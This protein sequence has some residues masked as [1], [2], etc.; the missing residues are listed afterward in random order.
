MTAN[1]KDVIK[2]YL[3][4]RTEAEFIKAEAKERVDVVEAKMQKLEA[5]LH[6]QMNTLGVTSLKSEFGTAFLSTTDYARVENWD[7]TLDFIKTND[8]YE[9]LEK[10]VSKKVVR[11]YIETTK[12]VPPGIMYGT[13][14]EVSVRKAGVKE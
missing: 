12:E 11:D 7:A 3:Q 13:K 9:L 4:L 5:Y 14:V 2:L 1:V 8:A 6:Q 10:R